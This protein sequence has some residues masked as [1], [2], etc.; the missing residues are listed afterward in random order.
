MGSTWCIFST[1]HSYTIVE[2]TREV[3]VAAYTEKVLAADDEI[4]LARDKFLACVFLAGVNQGRYRDTI[5][6]LNNNKPTGRLQTRHT[7]A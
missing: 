4:K 1:V 2:L 7:V 5:D 3:R 6:E